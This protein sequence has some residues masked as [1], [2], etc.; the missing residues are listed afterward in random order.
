MNGR[1][2]WFRLWWVWAVPAVLVLGNAVWLFGFHGAAVGGASFMARSVEDHERAVTRL[3]H[4]RKSLA[5]TTA[6]LERLEA[7]LAALR[8]DELGS[9]RDRL[10]PFLVD[11]V[12][13]AREA[14]LQPERISYA[15]NED[16]RTGIVHFTATYSLS[17]T[18][19]QIRYVIY[20]LEDSPQF[21]VLERLALRGEEDASSLDV[22][23]QLGVGTYF[24]DVDE[25]LMEQYGVK[26]VGD[27]A[28]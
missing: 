16:R 11:V 1:G 14:G 4:Q 13:R 7:N 22:G 26:E 28:D 2:A 5:E 25:G 8:D 9:M 10:V 24:A 18:Y 6:A 15:A 12:S 3:E 21:V 19:D 23:V 17:G 20:L 27:G